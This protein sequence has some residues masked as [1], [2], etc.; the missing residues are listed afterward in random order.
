MRDEY[1]DSWVPK[2][3]GTQNSPTP[4][5]SHKYTVAFKMKDAAFK[6]RV[7]DPEAYRT[8]RDLLN[9]RGFL[10]LSIRRKEL[11]YR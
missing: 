8:A 1:V 4:G 6:R 9:M 3:H 5:W 11:V 10:M 2:A 7:S